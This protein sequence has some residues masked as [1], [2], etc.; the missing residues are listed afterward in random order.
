MT[1]SLH[2][3]VAAFMAPLLLTGCSENPALSAR[4]QAEKMFFQAER[5]SRSVR[6]RPGLMTPELSHQLHSQYGGALRF[7]YL[8]LDSVSLSSFPNEHRE[9][10]QIAFR[11]ATRLSQLCYAEKL[12]D[13]SVTV[14]RRFSARVPLD[15]VPNITTHLNLGRALQA[16]GQWDSAL[17][18]YNY[19]VE[20]FYP[21][22]GPEGEI[23]TGV[24][25]LPN[26]IYNILL[27]VG[28]TA[29]AQTQ[30]DRAESYYRRLI[31]EHPGGNLEGASHLSLASLYE[32]LG[33]FQEAVNELSRLTDTT[34]AVAT[35]AQIR[36]ASLLAG[37]LERPDQA[38]EEYDEILSR[39]KGRD[40][41]QRPLIL[42]NKALVHMHRKEY[43]QARETMVRV[44][45]DYP[46]FY[47][48]TPAVQYAIALTFELQ[49]NLDR[50][51]TEY[52][53]VISGFPT[54]EEGLSTY[55]YLIEQYAREGRTADVERY[56][57][58]AEEQYNEIIATRPGTRAAA[59]AMSYKAELYRR[60]QDWP[61]ATEILTQVF[62]KYPTSEIGF[63]AAV[64]AILIYR[65]E[66]GNASAADSLVQALKSRL[67][68]VDE[69]PN[70]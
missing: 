26:H 65:D 8:M 5:A 70:F 64:V 16:A 12:Y 56:E 55:L 30:A 42:Y 66:L 63:R 61:R 38:I 21:P 36:I 17:S 35:P 34:G 3:L 57:Q 9:L 25:G 10:S 18:I 53:Y 4:Y 60:R 68:T 29:A 2:F 22:T 62:D 37:K 11:A 33:R 31:A 13:S 69:T 14:L 1:R 20:H 28:D 48:Q 15:G 50:A 54:S 51:E 24:F 58:R 44:K 19:S 40:T 47:N 52:K 41:L 39:L 27:R 59:A 46:A 45:H 6:A 32:R 23:L 43:D 67:T 7:C 49:N